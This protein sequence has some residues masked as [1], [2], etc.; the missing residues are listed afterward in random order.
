MLAGNS[1]YF[2]FWYDVAER[3]EGFCFGPFNIFVNGR[4][5]LSESED[6]FTLNIIA[7]D[8]R[9]SFEKMDRLDEISADFNAGEIFERAMHTH[10][11]PT[12]SDPVFPE[13]WWKQTSGTVSKLIDLYVEV[14][15]ERRC[16]PP[17][18]VELSMYTEISDKGWRFFLFGCGEQEI[19]LISKD[20]GKTVLSHALPKG[21]V[22]KAV[23]QFLVVENIDL[24]RS[25]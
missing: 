22:K 8:L 17:F 3:S 19:L 7:S 11:Y 10:G 16:N 23:E 13:Q 21:D 1:L 5:L 14:E 2:S 24:A 9:R 25:N 4:L 15:Q 18:G 20:R 6:N 12:A